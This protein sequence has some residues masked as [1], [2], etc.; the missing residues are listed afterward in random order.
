MTTVVVTYH[1]VKN[2]KCTAPNEMDPWKRGGQDHVRKRAD[3]HKDKDKDKDTGQS[4]R[5]KT[6]METQDSKLAHQSE[7]RTPHHCSACAP[8]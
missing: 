1:A 3:K 2:R 8:R 7:T 6:E 4:H 5:T